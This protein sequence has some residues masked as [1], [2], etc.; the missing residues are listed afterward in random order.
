MEARRSEG[1][2]DGHGERIWMQHVD[3][4]ADAQACTC[5]RALG[6]HVAAPR[7]DVEFPRWEFNFQMRRELKPCTLH[8]RYSFENA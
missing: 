8:R 2:R 6:K 3:T 7:R 5:K 4:R 1:P